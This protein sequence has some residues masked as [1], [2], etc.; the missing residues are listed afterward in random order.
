MRKDANANA[1]RKGPS[2]SKLLR[3]KLGI[4]LSCAL[5]ASCGHDAAQEQA[6][7]PVSS[8]TVTEELSWEILSLDRTRDG[9]LWATSSKNLYRSGDAGQSWDRVTGLDARCARAHASP[10]SS[11]VY[12]ECGRYHAIWDSATEETTPVEGLGSRGLGFEFRRGNVWLASGGHEIGPAAKRRHTSSGPSLAIPG[13]IGATACSVDGGRSWTW[14]DSYDGAAVMALHLT[15]DNMLTLLLADFGIRRGRL[16]LDEAGGPRAE[17]QTMAKPRRLSP[18]DSRLWWWV[19][20]DGARGWVSANA[21]HGRAGWLF[22]TNDGGT[23]WQLISEQEQPV[24]KIHRLGDGRWLKLESTL[25]TADRLLV[26]KDGEFV[27]FAG[28]PTQEELDVER[29]VVDATGDLL[30]RL[31][32]GEL[33]VYQTTASNWTR[34]WDRPGGG[35]RLP[36]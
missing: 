33:W 35:A 36:D 4:S 10:D 17:M 30:L 12:L 5:L 6:L 18:P 19:F 3:A 27:E 13:V 21:H 24:T 11:G 23:S 15:D 8:E 1:M 34:L 14:I 7:P 32:S 29:A 26:W 25:G 16:V 9:D 22:E 28:P 20:M 2:T 31:E